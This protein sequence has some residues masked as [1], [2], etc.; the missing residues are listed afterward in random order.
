MRSLP[1][2]GAGV[3]ILIAIG[4]VALLTRVEDREVAS[5]AALAAEA[6][7]SAAGAR[8]PVF[9]DS[10][11]LVR[12]ISLSGQTRL[13]ITP[14][15]PSRLT[16]EL[17][18]PRSSILEASSA[19]VMMQQVTR[20]RF[21]VSVI[22]EDK[23]TI[24]FDAVRNIDDANLW[25]PMRVDLDPWSG[26]SI[27][28]SLEARP[29][30]VR[31]ASWADRVQIVW[32]DPAVRTAG[33]RGASTDATLEWLEQRANDWGAGPVERIDLFDYGTNLA[34]AGLAS[35]FIGW[36][37]RRFAPSRSSGGDISRSFVA[38]TMTT[39]FVVA[40]LRSSIALSLGLVGALSILRFRSPVRTSEQVLY[41]LVCIAVAVAL[42]TNQRELAL[43]DILAFLT[44][45]VMWRMKTSSARR[46]FI[47]IASGPRGALS[48][49]TGMERIQG[50]VGAATFQ[51]IDISK[52]EIL[53]RARFE[54][55]DATDPSSV[56][57]KMRTR[58]PGFRISLESSGES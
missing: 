15:V 11:D 9:D 10:Q 32:G 25:Q 30:P 6:D 53:I 18:L 17:T 40:V 38:F 23:T 37:Y 7:L 13:S 41:L 39:T 21:T 43:V 57:S 19:L 2:L 58:L 56:V 3:V 49:E 29:N 20:V 4:S 28:L 12:S 55:D 31:D 44:V 48:P 51:S 22:A 50:M 35:L 46:P 16:F 26:R 42:G 24:V 8:Y 5:L 54:L 45:S 1:K 33:Q 52:D 27:L 36:F 34:L 14:P 47:V